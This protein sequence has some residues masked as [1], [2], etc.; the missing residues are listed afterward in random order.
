MAKNDLSSALY[1]VGFSIRGVPDSVDREAVYVPRDGSVTYDTL[2]D[3]FKEVIGEKR[4]VDPED[5]N[6]I[7][8]MKAEGVIA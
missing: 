4:G 2:N 3:H 8:S 6:L 1:D 7:T 5:V